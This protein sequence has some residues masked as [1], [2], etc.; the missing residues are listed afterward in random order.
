MAV[1]LD[2][3]HIVPRARPWIRVLPSELLVQSSAGGHMHV[4]IVPDDRDRRHW[5]G[6]GDADADRN[7]SAQAAL[8]THAESIGLEVE[9]D[10]GAGRRVRASLAQCGEDGL[11][12]QLRS[13]HSR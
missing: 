7:W 3:S 2:D 1:F 8:F 10:S 11:A 6:T 13:E 5:R 4:F 12:G 9:E